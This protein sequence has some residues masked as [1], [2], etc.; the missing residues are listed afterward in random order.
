MARWEA[1]T[2]RY[3]SP[4]SSARTQDAARSERRTAPSSY[5]TRASGRIRSRHIAAAHTPLLVMVILLALL[6]LR[7]L[8]LAPP[9]TVANTDMVP[10]VR[11]Q[12]PK[13]RRRRAHP[14]PSPLCKARHDAVWVTQIHR[15]AGYTRQSRRISRRTALSWGLTRTGRR[16]R[17]D[18]P[19]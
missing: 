15:A 8:F 14:P 9:A 3:T 12:Q 19:A 4:R 18:A 7:A 5:A 2:T 16:P 10:M 17:A 13:A 1:E 11:F 6:P